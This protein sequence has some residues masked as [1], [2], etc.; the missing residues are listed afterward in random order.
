VTDLALDFETRS[1][2]DLKATGVYPYAQHPTTDVW[3]CAWTFGTEAPALWWPGE[4]LPARI[5]E[6]IRAGG[7]L[8][9]WNA[10]FERVIWR[11]I[12]VPRY[13]APAP[14]LTQWVCTMAEAAAMALPQGLDA[15]A[16]ALG[17]AHTKDTEGYNL[18]LRMSRPRRLTADGTPV[19]WDAPDKVA[20]LGTYCLND[21]VVE[22]DIVR[23][24]R[25]LSTAE[26]AMYHLDQQINDRGFRVDLPLIAGAERVVATATAAADRA[27]AVLTDGAVSAVSE[28]GRL[29]AWVRAQGVETPGVAK[30]DLRTL[31]EDD[32][33]PPVVREAL[34]L[35]AEVGRSS[36]AKLGRMRE[37]ASADGRVR[38]TLRYHGA[39]TGRWSGKLV[40]P[41]NFPRGEV[42]HVEALIPLVLAGDHD[43]VSAFAPPVVV[44]SSLL[45]AC[46]TATE[47]HRLIAGDFSAI[48][49]RV[50]NW[51]AGQED[52]LA[53]FGAYDAGDKLQDPYVQNAARLYGIPAEQVQKFPHRQTGK[54]QELGC[55]GPDTLV[56]TARGPVPIV[57]VTDTDM[58]WDGER[59]VSHS[60]VVD[61]GEKEVVQWQGV[62]V[63]P[64]H[65]VLTRE[66][67]W[68]PVAFLA[69]DA[70]TR[71]R[72]SANAMGALSW[73]AYCTALGVESA[74]SWRS[75]IAAPP[76]AAWTST[77]LRSAGKSR[78]YDIAFAGP[79]NRYTILT[80][81]G[82]LVV[83]NCGYGMGA[84]KAV[85]A[86]K[87]VYGLTITAEEAEA[88]VGA[89][90]ASHDRVVDFWYETERACKEA[91]EAPGVVRRFG[92]RGRVR[93][94]AQ[95]A[96]LY[97]VLPSGRPLCYAAPRVV[98]AATPWGEER[99]QLEVSGVDPMTKQWGRLRL[100]GGLLVENIVQAVSRDLMAD[101]MA[102]LEAEG[103]PVVLTVHDEVVC[104]VARGIGTLEGFAATLRHTP[105]WAAGCP[106]A[107]D[108]WEGFRYRK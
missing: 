3:C 27:I 92:H 60:G 2:V 30:K 103:Y 10:Q 15:C 70:N 35:R 89:Y 72:D 96:Y 25:R 80:S 62:A 12:M 81:A 49:A 71:H 23:A 4:P 9:A 36:T 93:A 91:T 42:G 69:Q 51:L 45:R 106:V 83:H 22:R 20:R 8:R 77:T 104:D 14:A 75:A 68:R 39:S 57:L 33:T 6:H 73:S 97:V 52:V 7:R 108:V 88:I 26:L 29:A 74:P 90:R 21:V 63:T 98:L 79:R 24:L 86:A 1:T 54:F 43:A 76:P 94:V 5:V 37:S 40:Q 18:M 87:D 41:Q 85:T 31:L 19:W 56:L 32:A 99:E 13:G 17:V 65:R 95:G 82:A 47:G 102:A 84:K 59:F 53:R 50:L 61:Q 107:V 34:T 101:R 55:F 16:K 78:T 67:I 58:L 44:V 46:I 100:Y 105:T 64:D 11:E 38:G 28:A 66:G 48:E